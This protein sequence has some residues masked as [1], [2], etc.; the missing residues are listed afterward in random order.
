MPSARILALVPALMVTALGDGQLGGEHDVRAVLQLHGTALRNGGTQLLLILDE[1]GLLRLLL[2]DIHS[3]GG[4]LADHFIA[5]LFLDEHHDL[6]AA[7]LVEG[8]LEP[9]LHGIAQ[10]IERKPSS[11]PK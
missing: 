10:R 1:T 7:R 9:A 6:V 5:V 8:D 2:G 3:K 4:S 11:G